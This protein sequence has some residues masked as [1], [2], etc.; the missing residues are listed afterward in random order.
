MAG[1]PLKSW[2]SRA[3]A[4]KPKI[5]AIPRISR[6]SGAGDKQAHGRRAAYGSIFPRHSLRL[7]GWQIAAQ[8]SRF[9]RCLEW[10]ACPHLND[11]VKS[12]HNFDPMIAGFARQASR[13][14][15][16]SEVLQHRRIN[17]S[18]M[19]RLVRVVVCVLPHRRNPVRQAR[20]FPPPVWKFDTCRRDY[21]RRGRRFAKGDI[22]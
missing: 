5:G 2:M 18:A 20:P 21:H 7:P 12:R 16:R 1:F 8:R 13:L 9:A 15:M 11:G 10:R 17:V 4:G 22:R 3:A 14:F 19:V 6:D